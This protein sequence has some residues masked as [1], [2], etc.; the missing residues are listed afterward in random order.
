MELRSP[1]GPLDGTLELP[2][3]Q[4]ADDELRMRGDLV[5]EA[6][7][8]VLGDD[9]QLVQPDAHRRPHHDRREAGEL[10]V[11]VHRPLTGAAVVLDEGT[12]ALERRGVE[13]VEVQLADRDDVVSL[14]ERR[15]DV[16]PLPDT[17]VREVATALLV[18][19]R[20]AV[21]ERRPGVHDDLERFVLDHDELSRI[22]SELAGLGNHGNDGLAEV[23]DLA[24]SE[25]VILHMP[26]GRGCDLE[27]GIGQ[28]RHLVAGERSVDAGQLER[29]RDIDRFD[30]RVCVR[31]ADEVEIAHPMALHVVEEDTLALNQSPVLLAGNALPHC[32]ASLERAD[33][34]FDGCHRELPSPAAT[35]ASTMFQ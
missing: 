27:E 22:A 9:A 1:L 21:R 28:N 13:A 5:A 10:V 18:E 3:E 34:G 20:S 19:H 35:T 11:R 16:A 12:T 33:L 17:G 23:A 14:R 30:A 26:T 4:A 31:R 8:D 6:A 24:D 29:G 32:G 2:R 7:A 25:R 15:I